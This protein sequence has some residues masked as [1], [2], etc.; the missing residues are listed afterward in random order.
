MRRARSHLL[1]MIKKITRRNLEKFLK[2]HA[3]DKRVLDIGSGGSSYHQFFP[4]RL[5]L[6]VDPA[7]N[8]EVVGDAHNLPFLDGEFEVILCTEVLEHVKNP[9]KVEEEIWRVLKLG[10]VLILTTRFVFPLHDVPNDFW[11][12][13]KYGL[14]H[15]FSR[16]EI[17]ELVEEAGTMSTMAVLFQRIVFQ[18]KLRFNKVSKLF[19]LGFVWLL[20]HSHSFIVEEYGDIK[21]T[22]REEHILASGYYI[23]C[24]KK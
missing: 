19:L 24:R 14:A 13:T 3:T 6:D 11:R 4:H 20:D 22:E 8:P 2:R 12:F 16:W 9:F 21:K 23:V 17:V 10:G 5:T 7:R 1:K 18:T 15:L